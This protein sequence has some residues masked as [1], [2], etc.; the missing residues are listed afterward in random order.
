M[1]TV[2]AQDTF[3]K[4]IA[5]E[6]VHPNLILSVISSSYPTRKSAISTR[7]E[8]EVENWKVSTSPTT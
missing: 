8:K 4:K 2:C 3:I 5:T 6:T 1:R 7:G